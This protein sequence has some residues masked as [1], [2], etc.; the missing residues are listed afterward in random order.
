[1]PFTCLNLTRRKYRLQLSSAV[2]GKEHHLH[3]TNIKPRLT[4]EVQ[5]MHKIIHVLLLSSLGEEAGREDDDCSL[6]KWGDVSQKRGRLR[7]PQFLQTLL[8]DGKV[9]EVVLTKIFDLWT[10]S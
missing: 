2:F 6:H 8:R 3:P 7:V 10:S 9:V 1:M 4:E 5:H